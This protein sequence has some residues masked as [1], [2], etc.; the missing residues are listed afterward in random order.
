M[1]YF[2][3]ILLI[4]QRSPALSRK[5]RP[6][7]ILSS[8]KLSALSHNTKSFVFTISGRLL[9]SNEQSLPEKASSQVQVPISLKEKDGVSKNTNELILSKYRAEDNARLL[10]Q[11]FSG[12]KLSNNY[13]HNRQ[14]KVFLVQLYFPRSKS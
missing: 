2:T 1:I 10:Q 12:S 6:Y 9:R 7:I 14:E 11:C 3:T 5:N 13:H 4:L 8:H